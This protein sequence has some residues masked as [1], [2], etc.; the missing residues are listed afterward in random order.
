MAAYLFLIMGIASL[1]IAALL[2]YSDQ[3]QSKTWVRT[4][5]TVI[6]ISQSIGLSD[7]NQIPIIQFKD[8]TNKEWKTKTT[9]SISGAL[10]KIGDSINIY[11]NPL[12]PSEIM[13]DNIFHRFIGIFLF[14]LFGVICVCSGLVGIIK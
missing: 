9:S 4:T 6:D 10:Y 14:S 13:I 11:Y 3:K 1:L 12:N 8:E 7:K 5:G 2:F